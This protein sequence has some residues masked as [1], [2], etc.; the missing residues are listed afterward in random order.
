LVNWRK[1]YEER[2]ERL[3]SRRLLPQAL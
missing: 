3:T 2:D 1:V